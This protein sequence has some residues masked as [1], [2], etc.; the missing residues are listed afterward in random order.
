[1][2]DTGYSGIWTGTL[3]EIVEQTYLRA[4]GSL[5]WSFPAALGAKCA[6]PA[7]PVICFCGDGAFHY[8]LPELETSKRLGIPVVV[9][10]NNNRG[11]GQ[12]WPNVRRVAGNDDRAAAE[13]LR[14]GDAADFAAIARG[15]GLNGETIERP[16]EIAPA[17]RAALG[18]N[19]TTVLD[20]RTDIES[21]APEAS[22]P[23]GS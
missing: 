14:F 15:F 19:E 9:V 20:V 7:R 18:R 17:L 1:V 12:G 3:I 16:A 4:A 6:A 22:M 23:G 11:F 8:H 21:R 2:A 13:I 10:V 5:G